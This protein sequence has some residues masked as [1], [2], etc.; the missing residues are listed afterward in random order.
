MVAPAF[1]IVNTIPVTASDYIVI[2]IET[3]NPPGKII[4]EAID[5]KIAGMKLPMSEQ[6]LND[7]VLDFGFDWVAP[8]N[9]V[10]E[11]KIA[12]RKASAIESHRN[13]LISEIADAKQKLADAGQK[14]RDKAALMDSAPIICVCCKSNSQGV[15]FN[16]M[17]PDQFDIAGWSTIGCTDEKGMLIALR[18]WLDSNSDQ[19]TQLVGHNLRHFDKPK[20]RNRYAF[21]RLKLPQILRI[22]QGETFDTMQL[23]SHFS[24][25]RNNDR[26]ISLD[27][28]CWMLD[29][30]QPKQIISG[31]EVPGLHAK[32]EYELIL[33]YCCI[34]TISTERAFQLMTSAAIDL[35]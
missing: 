1:N 28:L 31:K 21:H 5:R 34:D 7:A 19:H 16:G 25:E 26:F 8:A 23:A 6:E 14:V 10:N 32:G 35:E 33:T 9:M 24:V 22:G 29:I 13:K 30:E 11:D 2:D 3:G 15:A 17:S 27:D 4:D 20:L 12:E 18:S